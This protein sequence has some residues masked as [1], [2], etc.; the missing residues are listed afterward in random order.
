[1]EK[2]SVGRA[3]KYG[4]Q[5]QTHIHICTHTDTKT[6]VVFIIYKNAKILNENTY[7]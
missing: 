4:A 5:K 7:W 3:A 2:D 1:M 6:E